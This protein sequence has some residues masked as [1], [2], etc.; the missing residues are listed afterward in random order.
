MFLDETELG[1][2]IVER[3]K[4][5]NRLVTTVEIGDAFAESGRDHYT[6][7]PL[8]AGDYQ[9]LFAALKAADQLPDRIIHLWSVSAAA[10]EQR[11]QKPGC[12]V[13]CC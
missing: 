9:N 2:Q 11:V 6:L 7:N 5:E 13:C 1:K 4:R 10:T 12:S 3:L 8:W